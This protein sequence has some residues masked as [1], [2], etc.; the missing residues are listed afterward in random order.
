MKEFPH[1]L[2][3]SGWDIGKEKALPTTGFSGTNDSRT[4][5]PLHV[6]QLDL[7]THVH[8]NALVLDY[9]LRDDNG[10]ESIPAPLS[11][12]NNVLT[13][14]AERLL[15]M[16]LNLDPPARVI[17]DVGAQILELSNVK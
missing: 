12:R 4:A 3:A 11:S 9:L 14:D 13:S 2:S 1:K 7:P 10:V 17:L 5:L 6:H 16:V 8:T 15:D